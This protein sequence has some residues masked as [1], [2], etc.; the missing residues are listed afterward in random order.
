MLLDPR[1]HA[2]LSAYF[3]DGRAERSISGGIL[4]HAELYSYREAKQPKDWVALGV[5]DH[6]ANC[7]CPIC[8]ED[9]TARPTAESRGGTKEDPES[10]DGHMAS[11]KRRV[12]QR[13]SALLKLDPSAHAVLAMWFGDEGE[14]AERTA[15]KGG[16]GRLDSLL[17]MTETGRAVLQRMFKAER[18]AK[19][20][21][22]DQERMENAVAASGA[23]VNL[24]KDLAMA[25]AEASALWS[26]ACTSW[27]K[28]A[29]WKACEATMAAAELRQAPPERRDVQRVL[30]MDA[31]GLRAYG[32]RLK[33][34]QQPGESTSTY[35]RRVV[36]IVR[37][38]AP[39][40]W[41]G[42]LPLPFHDRKPV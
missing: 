36:E 26:V 2:A 28:T 7:L 13:L 14:R 5:D 19:L 29:D 24:K 30:D 8:S 11:E 40:E 22:T 1:D 38:G 42:P 3:G 4:E 20:D 10:F 16:V 41:A 23:K 33:A 31:R 21:L 6:H 15:Q 34:P 32:V 17:T 18:G 39:P 12:G 35:R 9:I 37:R 25:R 27:L